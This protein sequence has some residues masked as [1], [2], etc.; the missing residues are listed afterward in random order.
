[1]YGIFT[2]T[3][4]WV[5]FRANVG[6][7]SIHGAYGYDFLLGISESF[8]VALASNSKDWSHVQR[9]PWPKFSRKRD[10]NQPGWLESDDQS[11]DNIGYR[12]TMGYRSS[13]SFQTNPA[14][15]VCERVLLKSTTSLVE[16]MRKIRILFW[17]VLNATQI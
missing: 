6:K 1:M 9:E 8:I 7:Y 2:C 15:K 4:I 14:P 11:S 3:Y 5:I 16:L 13:K 12:G 17:S 10:P